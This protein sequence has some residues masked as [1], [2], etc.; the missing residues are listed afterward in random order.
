[1][2]QKDVDK[3]EKTGLAAE[4][5]P[6]W[7]PYIEEVIRTEWQAPREGVRP[8]ILFPASQKNLIL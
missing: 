5:E 2:F 1:L 8:S 6:V 4:K 3:L 7:P